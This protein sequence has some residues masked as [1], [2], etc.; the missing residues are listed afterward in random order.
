M[1]RTHQGG[2]PDYLKPK[3]VWLGL[4]DEH[5][6]VST[7][8]YVGR[9]DAFALRLQ[10]F[11]STFGCTAR[12]QVAKPSDKTHWRYLGFTSAPVKGLFTDKGVDG[13][14]ASKRG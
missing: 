7:E 8:F 12:P 9:Q 11:L 4:Y 10:S 5:G 1:D 3:G 6:T 2:K 14:G 13:V